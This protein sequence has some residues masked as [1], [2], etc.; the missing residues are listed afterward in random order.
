[1]WSIESLVLP[2][3][4]FRV[5]SASGIVSGRSFYLR[6]QRCLLR[7]DDDQVESDPLQLPII[8]TST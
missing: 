4:A 6:S 5:P 8:N 7:R 1:M 3:N 2:L